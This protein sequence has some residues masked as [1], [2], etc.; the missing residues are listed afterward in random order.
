MVNIE[1]QCSM[2]LL[3]KIF[4]L[5][6]WKK[7]CV[8]KN[9]M[10]VCIQGSQLY[11][12]SYHKK[13]QSGCSQGLRRMLSSHHINARWCC[14]LGNFEF[15]W[16]WVKVNGNY[17]SMRSLHNSIYPWNYTSIWVTLPVSSGISYMSSGMPEGRASLLV[18]NL[19]EF[20]CWRKSWSSSFSINGWKQ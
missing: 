7:K 8:Y 5:Y 3:C 19:C 13:T 20:Q 15:L 1:V 11:C 9:H 4:A 10:N 16:D 2:Q 14:T 6:S 12:M 18:L 17:L